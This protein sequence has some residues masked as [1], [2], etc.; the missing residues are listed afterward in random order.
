[1]NRMNIIT[2]GVADLEKSKEFYKKLGFQLP[3]KENPGIVFFNAQGT[4]LALYPI[5]ELVKDLGQT[6]EQRT[7]QFSGMTLAYNAKSKE[8]VDQVF[9]QIESIGGTIAKKPETAF[10]G[11]YSGYFQ[12]PDGYYWEAAYAEFWQFDSN[13]MLVLG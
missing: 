7:G 4:K 1:M 3:E 8:E 9:A 12:D 13:D 6:V 5:A 10:W 2:L 11:G